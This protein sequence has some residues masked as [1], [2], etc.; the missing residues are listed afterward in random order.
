MINCAK[1]F[2]VFGLAEIIQYRAL[3]YLCKVSRPKLLFGGEPN[4]NY[5]RTVLPEL[6]SRDTLVLLNL[7]ENYKPNL[8]G[9]AP[10]QD[11]PCTLNWGYMVP[12]S[13]YLSPNRG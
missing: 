10:Y 1:R 4:G 2:R 9:G 5:E 8:S 12:N 3:S 11:L 7:P 13:G 6:P